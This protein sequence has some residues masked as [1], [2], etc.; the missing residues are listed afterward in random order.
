VAVRVVVGVVDGLGGV[1]VG[2]DGGLYI[3][4]GVEVFGDADCVGTYGVVVAVGC[5]AG[6]FGNV[7]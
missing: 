5:L 7:V 1:Y 6:A 4:V 2:E 3:G